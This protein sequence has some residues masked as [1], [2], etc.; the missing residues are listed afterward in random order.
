MSIVL[1]TYRDIPPSYIYPKNHLAENRQDDRP[2]APRLLVS[3]LPINLEQLFAGLLTPGLAR[4]EP[5][6]VRGRLTPFEDLHPPQAVAGPGVDHDLIL[7][8]EV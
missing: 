4:L 8:V 2:P 3:T 7:S 1:Y 5:D 6:F